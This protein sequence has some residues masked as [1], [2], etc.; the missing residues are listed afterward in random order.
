V[1]GALLR[2]RV[3]A[4]VVGV[5]LAVVVFIGIPLQVAG[6]DFVAKYVG[7]VHGYLY[8]VYLVTALDLFRRARVTDGRLTA[9]HLLAMVCAGFVPI[10]AFVAERWITST[11][12]RADAPRVA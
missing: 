9:K 2:Y 10:L 5:G 7:T 1:K 11:V 3:M 4:Y 8:I 6:N 12:E